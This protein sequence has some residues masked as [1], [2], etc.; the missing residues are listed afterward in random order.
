[1]AIK[2]KLIAKLDSVILGKRRRPPEDRHILFAMVMASL[3]AGLLFVIGT[4]RATNVK[5]ARELGRGASLHGWPLVYLQRE[6]IDV[7]AFLESNQRN[8]FPIPLDPAETRQWQWGNLVLDLMTAA[9][10][11]F[12]WYRLMRFVVFRY[13]RWK[14]S[15]S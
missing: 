14:K 11:I 8:E 12:L 5:Q 3:V 13:D 6:F 1:M 2:Q 9:L 7:Q 15:W 4:D 10:I